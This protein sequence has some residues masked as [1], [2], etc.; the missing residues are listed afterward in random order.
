MAEFHPL[1]FLDGDRPMFSPYV[2]GGIAGFHHNPKAVYNNQWYELQPLSTEGQTPY[3]LYQLAIPG[4]VGAIVYLTDAISIGI[5]GGLRKTFTDYLDDVSG[6]YVDV[7]ELRETNPIAAGLAY[8]TPEYMDVDPLDMPNP[9]GNIRGNAKRR[10]VYFFTGLTFM[11]NIGGL[12]ELAGGPGVY[13]P[14]Q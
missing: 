1:S 11:I 2:F 14:F 4:G 10:D 5:E 12:M 6:T 3:G 7:N 8:R 9:I 13:N